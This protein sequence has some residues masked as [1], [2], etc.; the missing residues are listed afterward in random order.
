VVHAETVLEV[1]SENGCLQSIKSMILLYLLK[2]VEFIHVTMRIRMGPGWDRSF[3]FFFFSLSLS[4]SLWLDSPLELGRFFSFLNLYTVCAIPRTG[5]SQ[6]QGRYLHTEQHKHR[7]NARN[8]DVHVS[9][10]IRT[11]DASVRTDEDGSYLRPRGRCD[12]PSSFGNINF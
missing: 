4:L 5:I 6:S 8:T 2:V 7:I 1:I 11:H 12:R 9:S 3:Q 10:G